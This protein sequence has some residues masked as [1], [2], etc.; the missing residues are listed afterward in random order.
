MTPI[1][2]IRADL[3]QLCSK[4]SKVAGPIILAH[5]CNCH[6]VWG[7][8]IALEFKRRFPST[9][10]IYQDRCAQFV[11]NPKELLGT[12]LM[13]PVSMSDPGYLEGVGEKLIV[14]CLFTGMLEEESAQQIVNS[15][16]LALDDFKSSLVDR[17]MIFNQD[18]REI[19]PSDSSVVTLN[20]P[21]INAGI[22]N[23]PWEM[24]EKV[25]LE[26]GLRCNV[27]IL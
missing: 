26:S 19:A 6:G 15:T 7:G 25:L 14:L 5:S 3:F 12:S 18:A 27:Y 24:T 16:A 13:I 21:K 2:Y 11:S 20:M 4:P 22:F 23:V 10:K 17:A 1:K 8:G 9:Y